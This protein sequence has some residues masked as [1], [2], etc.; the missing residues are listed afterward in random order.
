MEEAKAPGW[1]DKA[2]KAGKVAVGTTGGV[3]VLGLVWVLW[4]EI[5]DERVAREK[6]LA[7]MRSSFSSA[8]RAV[9][10]ASR[11]EVREIR[12]EHLAATAETNLRL[13]RM[14]GQLEAL[15]RAQTPR[16]ELESRFGQEQP[17]RQTLPSPRRAPQ[18]GG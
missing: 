4:G 6:A 14:Q 5:K 18:S 7:A 17:V 3:S 13:G 2:K 10:R 1:R 12:K 8:I 15:L 9:D 16:P 11:R